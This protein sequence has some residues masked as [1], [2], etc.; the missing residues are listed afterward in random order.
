MGT[1]GGGTFFFWD[2]RLPSI[3]QRLKVGLGTP[4]GRSR[5][6][7]LDWAPSPP[8]TTG[9][10]ASPGTLAAAGLGGLGGGGGLLGLVRVAG[11]F[12]DGDPTPAIWIGDSLVGGVVLSFLGASSPG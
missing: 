4:T 12:S 2:S 3:G 1:I 10:M 5:R 11:L 8:W 6:G 7:E 9:G